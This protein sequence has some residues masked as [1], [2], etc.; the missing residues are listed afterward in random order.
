M[1][2]GYLKIAKNAAVKRIKDVAQICALGA[3]TVDFT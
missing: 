2:S 1:L 3:F